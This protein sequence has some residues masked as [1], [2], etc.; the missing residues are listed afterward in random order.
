MNIVVESGAKL[1]LDYDGTARVEG[2]RLAGRKVSGL[3]SAAQYPACLSG[4]GMLYVQ[5]RG[6]CVTFR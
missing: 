1:A 5:P 4:R 2:V 3:I 6:T